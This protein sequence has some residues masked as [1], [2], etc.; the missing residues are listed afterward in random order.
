MHH[1]HAAAASPSGSE[2]LSGWLLGM[3]LAGREE[4][5]GF[6][7]EEWLL[8]FRS[9]IAEAASLYLAS[10][11]GARGASLNP[12]C[13]WERFLLGSCVRMRLFLAGFCS[14]CCLGVV[15]TYCDK[16]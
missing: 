13:E 7:E 9:R 11:E 5:A 15:Q 2:N 16:D 6:G 14:P 8:P 4:T 1:F 10:L 12:G 3:F